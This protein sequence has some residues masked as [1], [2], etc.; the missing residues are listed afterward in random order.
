ML[1]TPSCQQVQ[2][3]ALDVEIKEVALLDAAA[4]NAAGADNQQERLFNSKVPSELGF[5]LAGFAMGEGSFMLVCRPRADYRRGWKVSAAFNV[6]Q[7]DVVP[8]ELFREVLGCGTIR[9]AGNDGWYLEIN[10]LAHIRQTVI[11]FF[12]AHP[13][14][15]RK[16]LDFDLFAAGVE[17]LARRNLVTMSSTRY[18][19][20]ASCLTAAAKDTTGRRESSEAIRR[21]LINSD[22]R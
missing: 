11:P 17:I 14:V 9:R 7:K 2:Y 3:P 22:Q 12:R 1:G 15:G 20:Y 6:S 21:T 5:F 10:S 16:A 4:D 8:L 13:L 19:E 18:C